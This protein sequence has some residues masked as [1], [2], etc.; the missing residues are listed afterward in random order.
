MIKS[1]AKTASEDVRAL[2][3]GKLY[4]KLVTVVL[5]E[6]AN[7]T[8][9]LVDEVLLSKVLSAV[10]GKAAAEP[11]VKKLFSD[12]GLELLVAAGVKSAAENSGLWIGEIAPPLL[13]RVVEGV[14]GEV[15]QKDV[16]KLFK[17]ESLV[18]LIDISLAIVAKYP[19]LISDDEVIVLVGRTLEVISD[20]GVV[21]T[22]KNRE[23]VLIRVVQEVLDEAGSIS[24]LL[25]KDQFAAEVL[26]AVL[27]SASSN[28]QQILSDDGLIEILVSAIDAAASNTSL[29]DMKDKYKKLLQEVSKT[30]DKEDY[31]NLLQGSNLEDIFIDAIEVTTQNIPLFAGKEEGR[32]ISIVI[33][34]VL[35]AAR[36]DPTKLLEGKEM[37]NL[38]RE[39]LEDVSS[40]HDFAEKI[41]ADEGKLRKLIADILVV[42]N[43]KFNTKVNGDKVIEILHGIIK[44]LIG[45][46]LQPDWDMDSLRNLIEEYL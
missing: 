38:I 4:S 19:Q 46:D 21:N 15:Q 45:G 41:V 36:H 35:I 24:P 6:T 20:E 17:R 27:Q 30:L 40:D 33:D 32:I 28:F 12:K 5:G 39:I 11:D 10:L 31:R 25:I 26:A 43:D 3:S 13:Q 37:T 44:R 23:Q 14:V 8:D 2:L 1:V 18:E 34:N 9:V 7:H 29:I 22:F 16:N 42:I